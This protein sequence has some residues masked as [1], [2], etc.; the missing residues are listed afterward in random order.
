MEVKIEDIKPSPY[1]PRTT[2]DVEELKESIEKNG[3]LMPIVVRNIGDCYYELIDGDRRLH[4]LK[5]LGVETARVDVIEADDALARK[6]VWKINIDREDYSIEEKARYLKKLSD[7]GMTFYQIGKELS[8]DDQWVLA[9]INIFKFPED[10]QQAVWANKLTVSHIRELEPIIGAGQ[11]DVAEKTLRETIDR[12]LSRDELRAVIKPQVEKIEEQRLEAAKQA[13]CTDSDIGA[14]APKMSL[15]TPEGLEETAKIL[16]E[17]AKKERESKLTPEEKAEIIAEKKR[18]HAEVEQKRRDKQKLEEEKRKVELEK[19]KEQ[20]KAEAKEELR[21]EVKQEILQDQEALR[22]ML[23]PQLVESESENKLTGIPS[24]D[25]Q[26][27][28]L[29]EAMAKIPPPPERKEDRQRMQR[30]LLHHI[31]E[32]IARNSL[33]C[34]TCG[35]GRLQWKCGHKLLGGE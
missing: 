29:F 5:E 24:T 30:E 32:L 14:R 26:F 11:I 21:D 34:P 9:N 19:A 18:K 25:E 17:K 28:K 33:R 10:I 4:A 2:F 15:D 12:K 7:M 27:D 23:K 8:E 1:Q 6:M 31:N 16:R 3:L 22:E 20:G 35:E 13:I